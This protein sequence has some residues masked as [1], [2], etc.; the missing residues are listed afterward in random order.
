MINITP[1]QI[2]AM[3][4][5]KALHDENGKNE[6]FFAGDLGTA[7]ATAVRFMRVDGLVRVRVLADNC[8]KYSLTDEGHD[9]ISFMTPPTLN[10]LTD[11]TTGRLQ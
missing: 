9:L 11:R 10:H 2:E 3:H 5:L 8:F 6:D 7:F 1:K 4:I